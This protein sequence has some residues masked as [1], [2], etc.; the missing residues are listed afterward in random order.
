MPNLT[1][2]D[3]NE[4]LDNNCTYMYIRDLDSDVEYRITNAFT[5]AGK[6]YVRTIKGDTIMIDNHIVYRKL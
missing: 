1:A 5:K 6:V 4:D 3:I 2:K